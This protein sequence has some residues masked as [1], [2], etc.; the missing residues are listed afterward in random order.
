[1]VE[2]GSDEFLDKEALKKFGLVAK[3]LAKWNSQIVQIA[4]IK[5]IIRQDEEKFD[6]VCTFNPE[7][8]TDTTGFFLIINLIT[9]IDIEALDERLG[10]NEPF[11]MAFMIGE[12]VFLPNGNILNTL[13]K[14]IVLWP[15]HED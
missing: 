1:M 13:G 15:E 7:P 6:L 3:Q 5:E 11:D 2:K 12:R 4:A 10:I 9:R 8:A 14:H